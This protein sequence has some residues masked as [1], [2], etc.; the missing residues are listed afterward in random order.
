MTN[1]K[2]RGGFAPLFN[3]LTDFDL[4]VKEENPPF[5]TYN[6]EEA[7]TSIQRE[8]KRILN[9]RCKLS[10]KEYEKLEPE[11]LEFRFPAFF[12][13]PDGAHIN[14]KDSKGQ[15]QIERTMAKAI[16]IFE[17]RL[18]NVRVAI[19][20]YEESKQALY[21]AVEGELIVGD[22][23]TPLS[24]PLAL[25]DF[26]EQGERESASYTKRPQIELYKEQ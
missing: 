24:F 12:G 26:Q 1:S 17:P 25:K 13:I 6:E 4:S 20:E 15:H 11:A 7:R 5:V 8:C 21:L 9:T 3:R 18:Q 23:K 10:Q 2:N 19:Q 16:E 14:P 22:I